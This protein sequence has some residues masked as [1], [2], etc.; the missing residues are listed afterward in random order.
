MTEEMS[1]EGMK[2]RDIVLMVIA[3]SEDRHEFGRTSLQKVVY[4]IGRA[5]GRDLG[6]RAHY[7]GP[8]AST[9]E[10]ETETLVLSGFVDEKVYPLGFANAAGF[11]AK[12]YRYSLTDSGRERVKLLEDRYPTDAKIIDDVVSTLIAHTG[13]LDQ[14]VLSPAAKVDFIARQQDK[15]V[16]TQDIQSAAEDL[17]WTL[18]DAQ[19][20]SVVDLLEKLGLVTVNT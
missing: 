17:G 20:T 12:Q 3:R 11:E 2:V 4:F 7:Y 16:S 19:V 6:H 14:R 5:L 9:L 13:K 10:Q 8:F 1:V 15:P 18:T